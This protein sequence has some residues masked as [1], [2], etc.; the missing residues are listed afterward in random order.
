MADEANVIRTNS[1]NAGVGPDSTDI[2]TFPKEKME[3]T[4]KY[5][6]DQGILKKIIDVDEYYVTDPEFFKAINDFDRKAVIADAKNY[7]GCK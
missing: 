5:Y 2:G 6:Y 3:H 7:K 4:Q 1:V